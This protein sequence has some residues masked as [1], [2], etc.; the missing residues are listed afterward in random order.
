MGRRR[1]KTN[2][3][4]FQDIEPV[5]KDK[6]YSKFHKDKVERRGRKGND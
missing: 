5:T 6:R 1:S 3:E 2:Y 4:N